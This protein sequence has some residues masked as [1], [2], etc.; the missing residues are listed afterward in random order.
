MMPV[1][2]GEDRTQWLF[3]GMAK[4]PNCFDTLRLTRGGI[5]NHEA[6]G[7]LYDEGIVEDFNESKKSVS[8]RVKSP[9][10]TIY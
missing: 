7:H 8:R 4:S 2:R 1:S 9:E 5:D 3:Q 10:L 6:F